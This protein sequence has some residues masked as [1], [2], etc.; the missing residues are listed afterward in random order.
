MKKYNYYKLFKELV[1]EEEK[2]KKKVKKK[3]K[4]K[5]GIERS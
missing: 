5:Q 3:K 1:S 4:K 2:Q